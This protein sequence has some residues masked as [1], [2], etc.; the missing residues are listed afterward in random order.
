MRVIPNP[1]KMIYILRGEDLLDLA[2][3]VRIK[4]TETSRVWTLGRTLIGS[5]FL[6]G[7]CEAFREAEFS[8]VGNVLCKVKEHVGLLGCLESLMH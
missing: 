5:D 4:T 3:E 8:I 2:L 7:E 1:V 6:A